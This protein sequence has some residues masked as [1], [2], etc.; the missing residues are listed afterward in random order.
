MSNCHVECQTKCFD[1]DISFKD[2]PNGN[3]HREIIPFLAPE[4]ILEVSEHERKDRSLL[5]HSRGQLG[6]R[7]WD[8]N[9]PNAIDRQTGHKNN[10]PAIIAPIYIRKRLWTPMAIREFS[11]DFRQSVSRLLRDRQETRKSMSQTTA[12]AQVKEDVAQCIGY[13]YLTCLTVGP[14]VNSI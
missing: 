2:G 8:N 13:I 5:D 11:E 6:G 1:V 14:L 3:H 10:Q 12:P 4:V 7:Q 9:H